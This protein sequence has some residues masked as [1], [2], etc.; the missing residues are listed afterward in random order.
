MKFKSSPKIFKNYKS[1]YP[2][3]TIFS[4]EKFLKKIKI[5]VNY[6]EKKLSLGNFST[7]AGTIMYNNNNEETYV[8]AGKGMTRDLCKA[9]AY[10]ELAE[11]I[12][13]G[14]SLIT[15]YINYSF[16]RLEKEEKNKIKISNLVNHFSIGKIKKDFDWVKAF[17]LTNEREEGV[18]IDLVKEISISNGLAAGNTIEEA[19][20]HGFFEVCERYAQI[21]YI[22]KKKL[23]NTVDKRT[24][25]SK[26]I[27][28][29]IKMFESFNF[30]VEIKDLTLG[31]MVPVMGV[32]FTNNNVENENKII[33]DIYFKQLVLGSS[34]DLE[35]AILRCFTEKCQ[36]VVCDKETLISPGKIDYTFGNFRHRIDFFNNYYTD[37]DF[38]KIRGV[39]EETKHLLF[40]T[41]TRSL[42]S[43]D[44]LEKGK[45]VSFSSFE[46]FKTK[47]FLEDISLIK[48]TSEKNEWNLLVIDHSI[49]EC[50]LKVV[51]LVVPGVSDT[52]RFLFNKN[53]RFKNEK[54]LYSKIEELFDV[55][56]DIKRDNREE[57]N[58]LKYNFFPKVLI[59]WGVQYK[60]N[61]DIE[62]LAKMLNLS[63]ILNNKKEEEKLRKI[64]NQIV[65]FDLFFN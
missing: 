26:K 62:T 3:N 28:N 27:Q 7:Y 15:E 32:L 54:D 20:T 47:D 51:R 37:N 42:D 64:A 5:K 29:F 49:K 21:E 25:K 30:N 2:K 1:A 17:S 9:S 59:P 19:I 56:K 18:P 61:I 22:A 43:F 31:G 53:E 14:Y 6:Y 36:T 50:S 11:R 12:I 44:Y 16:K 35:Q 40:L 48:K 39:L 34:F 46:N 65:G 57:F 52:L 23:A 4:V 33:K 63:S 10:A 45:I 8:C 13:S 60:K 55:K 58:F 24:I 41:H 38:E